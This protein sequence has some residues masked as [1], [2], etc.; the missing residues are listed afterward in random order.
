MSRKQQVHKK[1]LL[2]IGRELFTKKIRV[3]ADNN[4]AAIDPKRSYHFSS[5]YN[6]PRSSK[7]VI[8]VISRKQEKWSVTSP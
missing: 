5:R 6:N 4:L 1:A 3:M 7:E 8:R 2:T